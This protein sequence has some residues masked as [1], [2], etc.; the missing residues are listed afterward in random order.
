MNTQNAGKVLVAVG[1][2]ALILGALLI[3]AGRLGLDR[4]PG[5]FTWRRGPV[6][7]FVP[8]TLSILAS[9]LLTLLLNLFLRR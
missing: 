7:V 9:L 8:L 6:T 3:L 2:T 5:N 1:L 4:L